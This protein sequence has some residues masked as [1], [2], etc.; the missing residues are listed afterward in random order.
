M[1]QK[2]P[3]AYQTYHAHCLTH[4]TSLV[5]GTTLLIPPL[6]SIAPGK[7][8]TANQ[9]T[10]YIACLFTSHGYGKTVDPPETI[11]KNTKAALD[12]LASQIEKLK[13]DTPGIQLGECRAVRINSGKFGVPWEKTKKI[14]VEG[15]LDMV[16]VRPEGEDDGKA[17]PGKRMRDGGKKFGLDGKDG[18]G[19]EGRSKEPEKG[20]QLK[21][22]DVF[23][24]T[25]DEEKAEEDTENDPPSKRTRGGRS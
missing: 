21:I 20:K 7:K 13:V 14:L 23:R 22:E 12:D 25:Q 17:E 10:H 19:A 4:K 8:Q 5:D 1:L 3:K 16:V 9:S 18:E 2:Y 6:Q 15:S 11:L 24:Q